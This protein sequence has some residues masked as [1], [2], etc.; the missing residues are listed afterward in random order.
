MVCRLLRNEVK[1]SKLI[2]VLGALPRLPSQSG[3]RSRAGTAVQLPAGTTVSA[4]PSFPD[5]DVYLSNRQSSLQMYL[6]HL[7]S[8]L[9]G[10]DLIL[11]LMS[12][13]DADVGHRNCSSEDSFKFFGFTTLTKWLTSLSLSVGL[14]FP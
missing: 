10:K 3:D 1:R 4:S 9:H 11:V 8:A 7:A 12:F 5:D 13:G 2:G 6:I 14:M